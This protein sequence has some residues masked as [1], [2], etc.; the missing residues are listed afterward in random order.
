MGH[1][2]QYYEP[3]GACV[4]CGTI[5][6][7][8]SDEHIVPYF[9]GGSHVLRE[10]SCADCARITSEFE[11]R[12]ARDLWG[13]A[14]V[15]FDAPSRR[16]RERG[17]SL[18]MPGPDGRVTGPAIPADRYPAGFVFYK[19]D[20]AGYLQGLPEDRDTSGEWTLAMIDDDGRRERFLADNP[21]RQ[22]ALTFRHVPDAFGRLLAKIGYGQ[23]LTG[24]DPS[25]FDPICLPYVLGHKSKCLICSRGNPGG[26]AA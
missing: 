24:L 20:E 21:D 17:K 6:G 12:V 19:M 4:Y 22:L 11:R 18:V 25:D 7:P 8:F 3:K 10:A 5:D 23:I 26:P 9:I 1:G 15:A 13:D 2:P 16:K 14:R